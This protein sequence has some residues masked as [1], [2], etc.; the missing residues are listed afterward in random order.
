M[1]AEDTQERRSA[2]SNVEQPDLDDELAFDI[3]ALEQEL[4][5]EFADEPA[6]QPKPAGPAQPAQEI[7]DEIKPV[8]LGNN[9]KKMTK[10]DII[11]SILRLG[12]LIDGFE[13]QSISAYR[14][15]RVAD[16]KEILTDL[17]QR[18]ISQFNNNAPTPKEGEPGETAEQARARVT[19]NIVTSN[20]FVAKSLFSLHLLG[21]HA[22]ELISLQ[23]EDRTHTNLTGLVDDAVASREDLEEALLDVFE[24]HREWLAPVLTSVNRYAMLVMMSV[25]SRAAQNFKKTGRSQPDGEE[26]YPEP[27]E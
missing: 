15:M 10:E 25:S 24:E 27:S 19:Q 1:E 20:K 7:P 8:P 6:Q 26:D 23:V 18:G 2:E 14:R 3:E 21:C 17:Q 12:A 16:L 5:Q 13:I 22:L 11:G 9:S 4:A